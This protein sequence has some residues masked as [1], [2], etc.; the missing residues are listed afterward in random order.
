MSIQYG[1]V[2][3]WSF[4]PVPPKRDS[5]DETAADDMQDH[6]EKLNAIFEQIPPPKK[7]CTRCGRED[8]IY[9][10][11][12]GLCWYCRRTADETE[13]KKRRQQFQNRRR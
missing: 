11:H 13:L 1:S 6:A 7:L 12:N 4:F 2:P 8:E 10:N 9:D 5:A 3:N